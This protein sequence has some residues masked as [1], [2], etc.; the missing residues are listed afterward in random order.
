MKFTVVVAEKARHGNVGVANGSPGSYLPT[1]NRV[2]CTRHILR[3]LLIRD[4]ERLNRAREIIISV[5]VP[6][7]GPAQ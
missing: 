2:R 5:S 4:L 1:F 7:E 6:L 3:P